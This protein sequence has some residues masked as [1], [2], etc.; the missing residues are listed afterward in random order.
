M[1]LVK[2]DFSRTGK[3]HVLNKDLLL[4]EVDSNIAGVSY[5]PST[6]AK[7][8]NLLLDSE[9]IINSDYW[10]TNSERYTIAE[11]NSIPAPIDNAKVY[12]VTRVVSGSI[13]VRPEDMFVY[14]DI[15]YVFSIY[16]KGGNGTVSSS[17]Q[18]WHV[19]IN[20]TD[21]S[22]PF[23]IDFRYTLSSINTPNI[24]VYQN[25]GTTFHQIEQLDNG[26][27][28]VAVAFKI[29]RDQYEDILKAEKYVKDSDGNIIE[30]KVWQQ[31][32]FKYRF[33]TFYPSIPNTGQFAYF[34]GQQ[35]YTVTDEDII[36]NQDIFRDYVSTTSFDQSIDSNNEQSVFRGI[37][38]QPASSNTL[39]YS[40]DFSQ[41]WT[42]SDNN[43]TIN[44]SAIAD[45][46]GGTDAYKLEYDGTGTAISLIQRPIDEPV[47]SN[48]YYKIFSVFAKAGDSHQVILNYTHY[49]NQSIQEQQA[50]FD[51]ATG[52]YVF[53]RNESKNP[54]NAGSEYIGNGWYRIYIV[55][56]IREGNDDTSKI[57]IYV[58][59]DTSRNSIYQKGPV[60]IYVFGAQVENGDLSYF[61]KPSDYIE[62]TE[63]PLTVS[64][65]NLS[66]SN[67]SN[68][69]NHIIQTIFLEIEVKTYG[70]DKKLLSLV[71][72][73]LESNSIS[74]IRNRNSIGSANK[75]SL[76]FDNVSPFISDQK[77]IDLQNEGETI[78]IALTYDDDNSVVY[79]N[80]EQ[81]YTA[82]GYNFGET[83]PFDSIV[84]SEGDT[85][86]KSFAIFRRKLDA[87]NLQ[88]I[89]SGNA[90][91]Q[92]KPFLP[93]IFYGLTQ[94][95]KY[96]FYSFKH[97]NQA[98]SGPLVKVRR[99]SD[100]ETLDLSES[101]GWV[102]TEE[103]EI[104]AQ[105]NNVYVDTWYD[106]SG[107]G[108]HLTN[109]DTTK[110]PMIYQAGVGPITMNGSLACYF[111]GVNNSLNNTFGTPIGLDKELCAFVLAQPSSIS[112]STIIGFKDSDPGARAGSHRNIVLNSGDIQIQT[113]VSEFTG[114]KDAQVDVPFLFS[115]FM[116]DGV[117]EVFTNG[118]FHGQTFD[119]Y[120]SAV[121]EFSLGKDAGTESGFFNGYV[122]E[123]LLYNDDIYS[124]R[125]RNE[126]HINDYYNAFLSFDKFISSLIPEGE[127]L[128]S[129]FRSISL[130][131]EFNKGL[132]TTCSQGKPFKLYAY[133][134]D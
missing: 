129:S 20:P 40:S 120:M 71:D 51:L 102:S 67:S 79:I 134:F 127:E 73:N 61:T 3:K 115:T 106:Q 118:I 111:D 21:N 55:C 39:D 132:L 97:V 58:S 54:I 69:I 107:F 87:D 110:Q 70:F 46:R 133:V 77:E 56:S 82:H 19:G 76:R 116:L 122:Q 103:L 64:G 32:T 65:E 78:S 57:A 75:I 86:I 52:S 113:D 90:I 119:T 53:D 84:F 80:G 31:D 104:F 33:I 96:S 130:A 6:I 24:N 26:W 114:S 30:T 2:F 93:I 4:E 12:K 91:K 38:L 37:K 131:R 88:A 105:D 98:Y 68:Y 5:K 94:Q 62:T 101:N 1:S 44:Q 7:N 27:F 50:I 117:T 43:F 29:T 17:L 18:E 109:A 28:R 35:L 123:V 60:S 49:S 10:L 92:I 14:P 83:N 45:P 74:I 48:Q 72:S 15:N 23:P 34:A 13:Y 42:S 95:Y 11:D 128:G 100:N 8:T 126:N 89:T 85:Y 124:E 47:D 112:D 36:I 99:S 125:I 22:Q 16:V 108:N 25:I 66:L 121:D 41:N 59:N 9:D 63:L 81:K